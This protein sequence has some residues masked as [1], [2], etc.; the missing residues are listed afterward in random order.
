[1]PNWPDA[2]IGFSLRNECCRDAVIFGVSAMVLSLS[3]TEFSAK[4]SATIYIHTAKAKHVIC[5]QT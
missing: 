2:L 4:T 1:M 5:S 3:V